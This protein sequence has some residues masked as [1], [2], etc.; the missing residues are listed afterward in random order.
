MRL[1]ACF[2]GICESDPQPF[3]YN[4]PAFIHR[5]HCDGGVSVSKPSV[6]SGSPDDQ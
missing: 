2:G 1:V 6:F 4:L 5:H 3:F